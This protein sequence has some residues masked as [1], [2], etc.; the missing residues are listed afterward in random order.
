METQLISHSTE[1][2][3]LRKITFSKKFISFLS[4]AAAYLFTECV[5]VA[6]VYSEWRVRGKLFSFETDREAPKKTENVAEQR[7][8]RE[9]R[10]ETHHNSRETKCCLVKGARVHRSAPHGRTRAPNVAQ[11][12][13]GERAEGRL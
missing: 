6:A 4:A 10:Q 7:G 11:A 8:R 3:L 13:A 9:L 12:S 1:C 2:V 5:L